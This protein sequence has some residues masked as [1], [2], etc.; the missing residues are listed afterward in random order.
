M[1]LL[2]SSGQFAITGSF[3]SCSGVQDSRQKQNGRKLG[4]GRAAPTGS[5]YV[6]GKLPAYPSPKPTFYTK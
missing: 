6:S 1:I 4:R 5:L 2:I 3:L